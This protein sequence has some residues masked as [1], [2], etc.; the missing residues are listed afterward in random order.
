[1][2]QQELPDAINQHSSAFAFSC[3][4]LMQLWG[5]LN[6]PVLSSREQSRSSSFLS[7]TQRSL[8][9]LFASLTNRNLPFTVRRSRKGKSQALQLLLLQ[10]VLGTVLSQEA[11]K[12][13]SDV[14]TTFSSSTYPAL[15]PRVVG[16]NISHPVL[17]LTPSSSKQRHS[18]GA[19][20]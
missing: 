12:R 10:F 11:E 8:L 19:G 15:E 16:E 2:C 14:K 4:P 6:T 1:M 20:M 9:P 5:R 13:K 18:A 3:N 7:H 17:L